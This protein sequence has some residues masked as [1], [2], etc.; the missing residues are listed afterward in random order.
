MHVGHGGAVRRRRGLVGVP[1]AR[2]VR[3]ARRARRREVGGYTV[4]LREAD[5]PTIVAA[6]NGRLERI[7]LGADLRVRA[8][9]RPGRTLRTYKSYFP[10]TD[11]TLGPGLAL[12]RG[13]GD[14]RGRPARR[15]AARP[16]D[17]GRAGHRRAARADRRGRPGVR[18]PPTSLTADAARHVPGRGA[19]RADPLLHASNPPPA[20]FRILVSPLVTWIW[21]GALIVFAGGLIALWPAGATRAQ[22]GHGDRPGAGRA[23]ARPRRSAWPAMEFLL[24]LRRA[25]RRRAGGRGAAAPR[26]GGASGRRPRAPSAPSSRPRKAAK[27]REIRDAELDYRTGKLSEADWRGTRPRAARRGGRDPAPA[28]RPRRVA[29]A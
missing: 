25:G 12:L 4:T 1:E 5:R 21:L 10:S 17:G 27:Y 3:A 13:R 28:R 18:G 20:T 26:P 7:D 19:R 8:R 16:L 2:D 14:E 23:R 15:P 11:P 22:P 29:H 9:R 6:G 24:V